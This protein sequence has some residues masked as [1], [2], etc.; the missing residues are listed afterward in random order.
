MDLILYVWCDMEFEFFIFL[1]FIVL[2]ILVFILFMVNMKNF[3]LEDLMFFFMKIFL[4]FLVVIDFVKKNK[5]YVIK[6]GESIIR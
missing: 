1:F 2:F 5:K 4:G 3:I 6:L